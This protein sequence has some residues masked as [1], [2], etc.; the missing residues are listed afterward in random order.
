MNNII[1]RLPGGGRIK[2]HEKKQILTWWD[3]RN[4]FIN[5]DIYNDIKKIIET[6][7][8]S[9]F[10]F[11]SGGVGA[12]IYT[13]LCRNL[14]ISNNLAAEIGCDVISI[15]HKILINSLIDD[16][17][18]VF[19]TEIDIKS[20]NTIFYKE[21]SC[22]FIKPDTEFLSTDSLAANVAKLVSAKLIVYIKEGSPTYYAG[23][24][25]PTIINKWEI[26]DI[27]ERAKLI[28][29]NYILDNEALNIIEDLKE[30]INSRILILNP[31]QLK[32][33]NFNDV[34]L[35]LGNDESFCEIVK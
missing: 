13:D 19:P 4:Y 29:G 28:K 5:T 7:K 15:M 8:D 24:K 27:R 33:L 3:Y 20:Y 10:F 31:N 30:N 11:I 23:F 26:D 16:G 12:F 1:V 14:N 6:N 17:I 21:N 25:K 2:K 22:F 34:N 32:N 35:G 9:K 18:N